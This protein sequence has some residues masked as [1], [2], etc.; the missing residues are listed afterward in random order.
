MY[1]LF[2]Q[3]VV[4]TANDTTNVYASDTVLVDEEQAEL[5]KFEEADGWI[6]EEYYHLDV[7]FQLKK[8]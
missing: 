6:I 2:G 1:E 8:K 5:V 7:D 4:F 3:D